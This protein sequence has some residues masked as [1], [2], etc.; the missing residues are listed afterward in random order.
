MKED[1]Q[2]HQFQSLVK[3]T[4]E[5]PESR[6]RSRSSTCHPRRAVSSPTALTLDTPAVTP[7]PAQPPVGATATAINGTKW[8][9]VEAPVATRE[10]Q[11]PTALEEEATSKEHLLTAALILALTELLITPILIHIMAAPPPCWLPVEAGR[12]GTGQCLRGTVPQREGAGCWRGHLLQ[13]SPQDLQWRG[14]WMGQ[15]EPHLHIFLLET[16]APTV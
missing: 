11:S 15:V 12:A 2:R 13:L 14:V 9:R 16:A 6:G 7:S 1:Q 5:L 3:A 8:A 4:L 10:K